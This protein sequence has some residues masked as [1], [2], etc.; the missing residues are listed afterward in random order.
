MASMNLVSYVR[1]LAP[2]TDSSAIKSELFNA[3]YCLNKYEWYYRILKYL[4][5][6]KYIVFLFFSVSIHCS[7]WVPGNMCTFPDA[8]KYVV[9][10]RSDFTDGF[11]CTTQPDVQ[12]IKNLNT[13]KNI[14]MS[15]FFLSYID[16]S[17]IKEIQMR[18]TFK[19]LYYVNIL[20]LLYVLNK[21]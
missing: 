1:A 15:A 8:Q 4:M 9:W 12:W 21:T 11:H 10:D 19:D 18:Q 3:D 14:F 7:S 16:R 6:F 13:R 20:F 17:W 2:E 5:C